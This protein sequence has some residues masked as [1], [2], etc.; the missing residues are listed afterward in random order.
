MR[1]VRCL[2]V[3]ALLTSCAK[4]GGISSTAARGA[5]PG[6]DPGC[7]VGQSGGG[8]RPGV[9][10]F[11]TMR[12]LSDG[13][14]CIWGMGL[15]GISQNGAYLSDHPSHGSVRM[16]TSGDR[17][18]YWYRP[19]PGYVGDDGFTITLKRDDGY[20]NPLVVGIVVRA[21]VT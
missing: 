12:V 2:V 16:Q 9:A 7:L 15:S 19:T 4:S 6:S 14:S 8:L 10:A 1:L 13:R 18:V 21:P 11:Q 3:A 17:V 5:A 20:E